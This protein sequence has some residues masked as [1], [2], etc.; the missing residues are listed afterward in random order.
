MSDASDPRQLVVNLFQAWSSGDPDEVAALFQPDAVFFDNVNGRFDGRA[1]I[2]QFYAGSLEVW[3]DLKTAP[4]RIWVDGDTAACVWTMTGRM[5][6]DRFGAGLAGSTARIDGMAWIRF[7]DGLVAHDEEYFDRGAP[8]AS[9]EG[10]GFLTPQ[11]A[12]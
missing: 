1:A 5:K 10:R 11:T 2:R 8:L 12:P 4:T 7:V 3:D 9:L 6:T